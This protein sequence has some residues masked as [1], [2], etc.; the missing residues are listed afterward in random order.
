MEKERIQKVPKVEPIGEAR[1]DGQ[2]VI[3]YHELNGI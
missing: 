1:A 2:I 3:G